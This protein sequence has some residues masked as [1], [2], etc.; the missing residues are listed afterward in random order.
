M[1]GYIAF[2]LPGTEQVAQ[3]QLP[4]P[5]PACRKDCGGGDD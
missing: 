5:P 1:N 3:S 2:L 4:P